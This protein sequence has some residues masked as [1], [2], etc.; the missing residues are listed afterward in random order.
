[1]NSNGNI[2]SIFL[3]V[4]GLA[5]KELPRKK[6][7]SGMLPVC[8][9]RLCYGGGQDCEKEGFMMFIRSG[10]DHVVNES[11]DQANHEYCKYNVF[12]PFVACV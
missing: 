4:H 6:C 8:V 10:V 2:A 11:N 12:L 9:K 7:P 1:M 3:T 5:D